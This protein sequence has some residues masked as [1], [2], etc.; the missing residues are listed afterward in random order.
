M[1]NIRKNRFNFTR[2]D[3]IRTAK[4]GKV[5]DLIGMITKMEEV[6]ELTYNHQNAASRKSPTKLKRHIII[7]DHSNT[8]ILVTVW[9][10]A[11][12]NQK[13]EVGNIIA[14]KEG[15]VADFANKS[16]NVGDNDIEFNPEL[17]KEYIITSRGSEVFLG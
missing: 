12:L 15:R 4:A 8:S 6:T 2:I 10:Q 9:G 16:V 5:L 14:V 13:F 17:E 3:K 1:P 11:S 7:A